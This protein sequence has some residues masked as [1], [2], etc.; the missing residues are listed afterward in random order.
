MQTRYGPYHAEWRPEQLR[1]ARRGQAGDTPPRVGEVTGMTSILATAT[2]T[3]PAVG[4]L[5]LAA[6]GLLAALVYAASCWLWPYTHC[7]RCHG[8][9]HI[10]RDDHKV[11]RLC[12]RC[13]GTGRRL[14]LGRRAFNHLARRRRDAAR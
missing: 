10:S 7:R 2:N 3:D 12:R 4:W 6:A 5:L 8:L 14:R 13:H 11:F 9:G 1:Q